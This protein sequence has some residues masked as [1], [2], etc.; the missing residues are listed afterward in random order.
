VVVPVTDTLELNAA[1]RW[2]NKLAANLAPKLA[3]NGA[4]APN[5]WCAVP[6]RKASAHR[7]WPSRQRRRVRAVGGIR[8]TVR[9]DETNAMANLLLKSSARKRT[10]AR[11]AELNC[12]T[13]AT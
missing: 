12:S 2:T 1:A 8:D 7:T 6:T 3:C 10:W 11:P 4:R 9:C 5:C 13:T